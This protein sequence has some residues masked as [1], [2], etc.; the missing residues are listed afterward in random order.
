MISVIVL[1]WNSKEHIKACLDSL[2]KEID[3]FNRRVEVFVMDGGSDDGT[4]KVLESFRQE[5]PELKVSELGRNLGTTVSRNRA[6]EKS[7]GN[8]LLFLD[9]DTIILPGLLNTLYQTLEGNDDIGLVAPRLLYK[10]GTVQP[11]C[12]KYPTVTIKLAKFLPFQATRKWAERKEL[13]KS[14]VYTKD[15]EDTLEVDHCISAAWLVRKKLI[16]EIGPLDENI[17]YAPEDVD[18]CLRAWLAGYKVI[19]Q[20]NAKVIHETQRVGYKDFNLAIKHLKG[21]VYY[22]QKH[23]YFFKRKKIYDRIEDQDHRQKE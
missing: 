10:D 4:L 9:S 3:R 6:I 19:Y 22:F 1:T 16:K 11:S 2:F 20:P 17:F 8:Y 7:Q 23:N 21:L 13:Y 15:F 12:K 14:E 18:F 5:R